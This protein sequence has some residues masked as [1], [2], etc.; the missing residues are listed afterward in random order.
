MQL[1]VNIDHIATIRQAR[2]TSYPCIIKA[3]Q[4]AELAGADSITLHLREDRRHMQDQDLFNLKPVIQTKMN[5]EMA[6]TDEMLEIAL[7]VMPEDICLVPERREERTTEGGLNLNSNFNYLKT[8][9]A[10]L[11]KNGV[12]VSLFISP[13]KDSI[14]KA[15]ELHAP[16]IELHTGHYADSI[17]EEQAKELINIQ[18][19]ASYAVKQGL[20]VNAG[21]GLNYDN[22]SA[23]AK[24]KEINELNIGHAI[25]AEALFLGWEQAIIRMKSLIRQS[26]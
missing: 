6:A 7:Q 10:E 20:V 26:L 11:A 9:I 21:H 18:N 12:R 16:V 14:D 2:G 22:V 8:F 23:I 1:G 5:L 15:L 19:M 24:I 25:V 4:L 13:D 17:S 3:T